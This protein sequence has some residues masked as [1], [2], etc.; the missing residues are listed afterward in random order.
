MGSTILKYKRLACLV[1]S[2]FS[3]LEHF[4]V[5]FTV[6]KVKKHSHGTVPLITGSGHSGRCRKLLSALPLPHHC[7]QAHEGSSRS[8]R[9]REKVS[10]KNKNAPSDFAGFFQ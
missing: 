4:C 8:Q 3:F 9:W 6:R 2:T 10:K 7:Q 1:L 5:V